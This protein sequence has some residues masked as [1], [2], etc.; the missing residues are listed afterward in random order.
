MR[1]SIQNLAL[2]SGLSFGCFGL[3]FLLLQLPQLRVL[4]WRRCCFSKFLCHADR[5]TMK[6]ILHQVVDA[7]S[8]RRWLRFAST[9]VK[10]PHFAKSEHALT[11]V[12]ITS[13]CAVLVHRRQ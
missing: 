12:G 1:D 7:I 13:N 2:F 4:A 3:Q 6:V 10:A 8:E 5:L 11:G 9:V